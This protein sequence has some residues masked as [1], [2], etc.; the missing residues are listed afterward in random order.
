MHGRP[1]WANE[2]DGRRSRANALSVLSETVKEKPTM[3]GAGCSEM[4]MSC[5]VEEEACKLK[6]KKRR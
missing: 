1:A 2:P 4:L 5:A 3:L 6:E